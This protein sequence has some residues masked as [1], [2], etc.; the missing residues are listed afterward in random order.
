MRASLRSSDRDVVG[1][2]T[3][4]RSGC[5]GEPVKR[6][7]ETAQIVELFGERV[8]EEEA[9]AVIDAP[10][11]E[12]GLEFAEVVGFRDWTRSSDRSR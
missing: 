8:A 5:G 11:R 12:Q 9:R 6:L 1:E 4:A 10:A 7:I 2:P 3:P